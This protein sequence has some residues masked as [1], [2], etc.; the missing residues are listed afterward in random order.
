MTRTGETIYRLASARGR[1][2]LH[3]GGACSDW[4]SPSPLTAW[5]LFEAV[6]LGLLAR[7]RL[8]GAW[9]AVAG[10]VLRL[11]PPLARLVA[12]LRVSVLS[13]SLTGG[14]GDA[15]IPLRGGGV[16]RRGMIFAGDTCDAAETEC[17]RPEQRLIV[18]RYRRHARHIA[19]IA[20]GWHMIRSERERTC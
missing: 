1:A 12:P 8:L 5:Q 4:R 19:I 18:L 6:A 9:Y 11:C 10:L 2:S 7:S 16:L 3:A 14:E 20:R 17:A 15:P 13:P